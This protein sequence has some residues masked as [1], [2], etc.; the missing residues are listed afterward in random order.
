MELRGE[1]STV[2]PG[3]R[4]NHQLKHQCFESLLEAKVKRE[5][6]GQSPCKGGLEAWVPSRARGHAKQHWNYV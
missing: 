3:L 5:M 2:K 4:G 1:I 6:G